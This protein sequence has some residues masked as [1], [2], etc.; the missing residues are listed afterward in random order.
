MGIPTFIDTKHA[1]AHNKVMV[2]DKNIVITGSFNFTKAAENNN[3]ENLIIIQSDKLAE[4]YQDN[5]Y[6]H[7]R[8]S[9][10]YK[11]R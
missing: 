1:I 9:S 2:I 10:V 3:A 8:H 6:R 11:G 4:I 7:Q 5:W